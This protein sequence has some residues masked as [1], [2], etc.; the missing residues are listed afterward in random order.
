VK[1]LDLFVT[2]LK[3][4]YHFLRGLCAYLLFGFLRKR[5][6]IIGVTGTDGKTTTS[7]MIYHL[8]KSQGKK[9]AL[10]ST[11]AAYIG[12]DEIDTGFHVTTP[13]T[14]ALYK[15]L[16][17][18]AKKKFEYVVLEAT[19]HGIYQHRLFGINPD[20]AVLTNITHEHLDYHGSYEKYLKIKASFLARAKTAIINKSDGSYKQVHAYL[21][22]KGKRVIEYDLSKALPQVRAFLLK[23]IHEPYNR[24][25]ALAALMVCSS[26]HL[27]I[28][29]SLKAM[30]HF[31][32]VVGRMQSIPNNI[33]L[34]IVVDF[35]HTPNALDR[36]LTSLRGQL[37]KGSK[38]IAVFGAAGL[39][40]HAKRPMM[41]R[42][43]SE[44]AD[45][46]VF[47]AEDPRSE[48]VNV[49]I[50]QMKEGIV[51]N[52]GHM[53]EIPDRKK[54]IEFALLKLARPGDVVGIFGKGHEKSMNLDGTHEIP[55]SDQ[56][57]VEKILA[58]RSK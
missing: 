51:K 42:I 35:A 50:R 15:L 16:S 33:G 4:P 20:I 43:A 38:L 34:D 12:Q 56:A 27:P 8:L 7:T 29:S 10:I 41:G 57:E 52:W 21:R 24:E 25:N 26:L 28:N 58:L 53:H 46:A 32:G 6:K 1:R 40:D 3:Q 19:S 5:P 47:T 36:A 49:I 23:E 2:T 45:M 17:K 39:R 22:G 13:N 54:A 31:P 18:I 14:F 9:V 30:L 48:D 55:W 37:R 44:L 11:V